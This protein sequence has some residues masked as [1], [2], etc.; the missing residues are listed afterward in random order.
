[1]ALVQTTRFID[2]E[3]RALIDSAHRDVTDLLTA[4][5]RQLDNLAI[6]LLNL[7][8]LDGIDAYQAA[9]QPIHPNPPPDAN[10]TA[11]PP[12]GSPSSDAGGLV[13]EPGHE[14]GE[15]RDAGRNG[16]TPALETGQGI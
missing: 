15:E 10:R 3:V 9:G 2:D 12:T 16:L 13:R 1:L 8:T 14:E 7:E 4:H 6:A 11:I 5:R